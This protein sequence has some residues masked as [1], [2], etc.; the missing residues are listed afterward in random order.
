MTGPIDHPADA[1]ARGADAVIP[2]RLVVV[3]HGQTVWSREGRHTGRT[4]VPLEPE[5]E[6]GARDVGLRLGRHRFAAVWTS[7]RLRAR[8]T[9]DLA[10]F[11]EALEVPE[12]AEWDYGDYEGLT[13]A[14]IQARR[15]GWS[16]WHD[17]VPGGETLDEI[18]ARADAVVARA[19]AEPG[20]VLAFA[21]AHVLRVVGA[22]W[23]GLAPEAAAGLVLGPAT[24][25]VLGWERETPALTRWND[26]GGDP[27][28]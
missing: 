27:V 15:P 23:L 3:R 17:G 22:R 26:G 14:E 4:D 25:S 20:D 9:A 6:A 2:G 21:H 18:A 13:T 7:P 1:T 24:V 10:G 19:R 8:R 16:L 11:P 5:G 12:L 28:A